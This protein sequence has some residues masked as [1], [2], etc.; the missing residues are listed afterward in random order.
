MPDSVASQDESQSIPPAYEYSWD[1]DYGLGPW[2]TW[3]APSVV[4]DAGGLYENFTRLNAPG[5]LDPNHLD[6]IGALRLVAHLSIPAV[7][8]PGILNLT[9]AEFE[10]TI[11]A[12][13]YQANGGKLVVWLCRYVPEEGVFR[14]YY[15]NLVSD[16]WANT[17]ADLTPQL[18][19]GEWVTITVRLSDNPADWTYAG[20]NHSQQGD[21]ADRYQ[22]SSLTGTLGQTDATLHLVIINDE[23]DEH[24]TGFLDIANITVR[25]QTPAVPSHPNNDNSNRE[26][27]N[28]L[29]DQDA[30]GTLAGDGIVDLGN[31]TFTLVPGSATN[32]TVTLDPATGAFVFTPNADYFGPTDV[33]GPATFLY[34]VTDGTH[35]SAVRTAYIFIG[36][37]NDAPTASAQAE[38][39]EI[40]GG[41][42]FSHALRLGADID[43]DERLTYHLVGGSETNGAVTLDPD[44][45][46]YVFTPAPGFSGQATFSYYV[47]DGQL[48]SAPKT[49]TFTVLPAGQEP[50][51]LTYDQAVDRLIA[52]DFESFVETVILL[53]EEGHPGAATFYGTWLRYGQ[54]VPMDTTLAAHYLEMARSVPDAAIILAEMYATGEGVARDYAEAR[55][56]YET[57]PTDALALYRLAILH[58]NGFGGPRDDGKAVELYLQSASLGNADAMYTLGRRYL[59]GE[60]VA[61]SAEDAYFWL[62][63][64]MRLNGGPDTISFDQLLEFN[65]Q[66]AIDLGLS[67]EQTSAL[68]SAIADWTPGRPVPVNDAPVPGEETTGHIG[69]SNAPVTGTL[70]QATDVDGQSPRYVL[71]PG[72]ALNGTVT[73]DPE[74]GAFVFNPAPDYVGPASFRYYVT[75]GQADSAEVGVTLDIEAGTSAAP[76]VDAVN[77]TGSLS[78]PAATGLLANDTVTT[79]GVSLAISAVNGSA[80]NVGQTIAGTY[81]DIRINQDGSYLFQ[82]W[83]STASLIQGQSVVETV[84]YAITDES[85]VTSTSTLT[86]TITG[87]G[88]T[89]LDGSGVLIGSA[90]G[91]AITGGAGADVIVGQGGDDVIDAGFDMAN[92]VYG[93][94]GDD[95][96]IVSVAGDTI[97]EFEN[98]GADTVQTAL[99]DYTL[100]QHIEN[101][102]FIGAGSFSGT[103]TDQNNLIRGGA[104][105]DILSGLGG[106]DILVGG[107]GADQLDG[108]A[109]VDTAD[110]STSIAGVSVNLRAGTGAGGHAAGDTL[111]GIEAVIGS[112]F[113]DVLSGGIGAN[114]L[115]GGAGVD[116]VD[117]SGAAAGVTVNLNSGVANNDG[118]GGADTLSGFENV[119]GS[120]FNDTLIGD[121]G[122]N[123]LTGGLGV[124]TLV[125]LAGDDVLIGGGGA[126]NALQG[127]LGDDLYVVAAAGDTLIEFAGEGT[128]TV[129]TA[130]SAYALRDHFEILT[131]TGSGAFSGTGNAAANTL[132]G[133]SG[134]DVL[135]GRGGDDRLVGG[136]GV[137]TASYAEAVSAVR[138][139]LN[140]GRSSQDGDGGVDT[141]SGI[142]NLTGSAFDDV[143]IGDG[144]ANVL[145]GGAGTDVLIGLA[146]DDLL[147]GGGGAANALQGGL[148]DDRYVLEAAGDTA[149][150]F[151]GEGIDTV[152]TLMSGYTLRDHFENLTYL[153]VANFVGAGNGLNNVITGAGGDDTL[154]GGGGND[155]LNGGA[156]VDTVQLSGLRSGYTITYHGGGSATVVDTTAG[157]GDDGTDILTGV[158]VLRFQDGSTL[159]LSTLPVAAPVAPVDKVD[160]GPQVLPPADIAALAKGDGGAQ[161]MPGLATDPYLDLA[162]PAHRFVAPLLPDTGAPAGEIGRLFEQP[163]HLPSDEPSVTPPPAQPDPDWMF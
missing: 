123:V 141:F 4:H 53:A 66:Q 36:G 11:R 108:G 62:G 10:I 47:S 63:V 104:S 147:I 127:G 78:A 146:G 12:T 27:F 44:N 133:G 15:V 144:G 100:R 150:E 22:P 155:T 54:N 31:A 157:D 76:D 128:D 18:V 29:E 16:N 135:A 6:G 101:L 121:A 93:G 96:F 30:I 162:G 1:F 149:I 107:A 81:G 82:A 32:G 137:D 34:T 69:S 58:D 117:Y 151:E 42:S 106:E 161:V 125:G 39:M 50:V 21:W 13:D 138:A 24:P 120:A 3:M 154:T 72:S 59:S 114:A 152:E 105:D 132:N 88:G 20:E 28:G 73:I 94:L 37:V 112:S 33:V 38:R 102:T 111:I 91:D 110:Y 70:A 67:P 23:P 159:E 143:L 77:E 124:D 131:F 19:E 75:D 61:A 65:I 80:A 8:S 45:G 41:E 35:T 136:A 74:T 71:A 158:E 51:R 160:A 122:A 56:L 5:A 49:V 52:G 119:V 115:T 48:D 2:T 103:G 26:I 87:V 84:A 79:A 98:E 99:A 139:Q 134:D 17:G 97:V 7:G 116:T 86:I 55:A 129:Q 89:I 83:P 64:G 148:G 142:E 68:D 126:A 92:E 57:M 95:T 9:D 109:G 130:L 60:G 113:D 46:R 163:L 118:D 43:Q 90:F 140:T 40:A 145:R 85:G 14:N 153:G 156:G 25:T